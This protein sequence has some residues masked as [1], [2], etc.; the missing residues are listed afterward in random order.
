MF[1]SLDP[2]VDDDTEH[3]I[4]IQYLLELSSKM[5]DLSYNE[6]RKKVVEASYSSIPPNK[7]RKLSKY[8]NVPQI[9]KDKEYEKKVY[10]I[11]L[12][13]EVKLKNRA[14]ARAA[15]LLNKVLGPIPQTYSHRQLRELD[16]NTEVIVFSRFILF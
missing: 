6:Y 12:E 7:I 16:N 14:E 15:E 13:N 3:D 10:A 8:D 4:S 5:T 2:I 11:K 9:K 1:I